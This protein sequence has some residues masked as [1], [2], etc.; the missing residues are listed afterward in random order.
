[1]FKKTY[2]DINGKQ[3]C[4]VTY[5]TDAA[6]PLILYLHGG[7]G[8]VCLPL[9]DTYNSTLMNDYTLVVWEQRG[10][11]LSYY[12]FTD[13]DTPALQDYVD[14]VKVIIDT[15]LSE[16]GDQKVYMIGHSWG[17]VIALTCLLQFPEYIQAY[18]GCGQVIN[19]QQTYDNQLAFL[20]NDSHVKKTLDFN[21]DSWMDHVLTTTRDIV[22]QGGSLYGRAN[23][24]Y[25]VKSFLFSRTY[26]IKELL[27]RQKGAKQSIEKL[28]P[29]LMTVDFSNITR[30]DVPVHLVESVHDQH[31]SAAI[32]IEWFNQ[33]KSSKSLHLF[34][35]SAHFPQW[36]EPDKFNRLVRELFQ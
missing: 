30:L 36:E 28:W 9:I 24:L 27:N 15:L 6:N 4:L 11:G 12:P 23:Y 21:S 17:S 3:Q 16:Y 1:M 34:E 29:E 26:T 14:D 10:A 33:L 35:K 19:M 31:V 2:A 22:K 25:L 8:D 20:Y 18:I 7:P 32:A 13:D 5:S